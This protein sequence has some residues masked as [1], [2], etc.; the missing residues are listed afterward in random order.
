MCHL[1][2]EL[3]V[4]YVFV[5]GSNRIMA[6][7]KRERRQ[8]NQ[9]LAGPSELRGDN[10]AALDWTEQ[11]EALDEFAQRQESEHEDERQ[12]EAGP[13]PETAKLP[14]NSMPQMPP[15]WQEM[16]KLLLSNSTKAK[17]KVK[18]KEP[19]TFEGT[20]NRK[21][22]NTWLL[23][24]E[25]YFRAAKLSDKDRVEVA[26][27]YLRG[28]AQQWWQKCLQDQG[29]E[30]EPLT[31]HEFKELL[32]RNF[33]PLNAFWLARDKMR[34][35]KQT[36]DIREYVQA[37]N[38]LLLEIVAEL[39]YNNSEHSATGASPFQVVYGK[40]P[41]VPTTWAPWGTIKEPEADE[42]KVP[43]AIAIIKEG[44]RLVELAKLNIAKACKRYEKQ[45]NRTRR[46]VK[47]EAGMEV[48]LNIKN[49]RLPQE[50]SPKFVPPYAGPFRIRRIVNEDVYELEVV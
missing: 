21:A 46:E 43:V 2:S 3:R 49:F 12:D 28:Y 50:V 22:L 33:V 44:E 1:V 7:P 5:S 30:E 32:K 37:F 48:W 15:E 41:L 25:Q 14:V 29:P 10:T 42:E 19:E 38:G 26:S 13:K 20:R 35:L 23:E 45:A 8:K 4:Q 31:W 18:P 24:L 27:T 36:E 17:F 34:N 40:T 9:Q 6:S 47:F 11:D 16:M 39:C